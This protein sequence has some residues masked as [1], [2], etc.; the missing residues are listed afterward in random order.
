MKHI[1]F[2]SVIFT[3]ILTGCQGWFTEPLPYYPPPTPFSTSTPLIVSPTP[4]ILPLPL[5]ATASSTPQ[6][7]SSPTPT[8][9]LSSP[10]PTAINTATTPGTQPPVAGQVRT[11]IL[12][13]NTSIDIT[14][15]MGEVTNAY[16]TISNIGST[17]IPNMCATL[18]AL[19]EGRPHPDKTKCTPNLPTGYQITFKLTVDTTLKQDTPIQ[20]EVTTNNFLLQRVGKDSCRD[21]DVFPPDLDY[22]GTVTPNP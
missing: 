20:V 4:V 16:V 2:A 13:C 22:L 8:P 10:T 5:T 6:T 1:F 3:L 7:D 14:H 12:A 15:Q 11:A 21:I 18:H 17:D 19:D 9:I